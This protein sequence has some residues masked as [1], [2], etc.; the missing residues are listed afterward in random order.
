MVGFGSQNGLTCQFHHMGIN[1]MEDDPSKGVVDRKCRVHGIFNLFI[2]GSSVSP[3]H[4]YAN[5]TLTL[6]A[7]TLCFADCLRTQHIYYLEYS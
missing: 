7:L 4:S 5:P 6:V 2:T 1:R 3:A